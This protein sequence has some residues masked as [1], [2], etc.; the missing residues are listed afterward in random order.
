MN[1]LR[2]FAIAAAIV[3]VG[4]TANAADINVRVIN[5]SNGIWNT[6]FVIAAHPVGTSLFEVG[7]PASANLQAMAEGGDISG[8]VADLT[9]LG[10]T[11]SQDPAGGLLAPATS[12][13]V[14]L[15]TDG[16]SNVLLSAV[17]MLLPTNDGFA[18]LNGVVIPT[19]PGTYVFDVPA[20]DA[21]TE[22]NDE[23]I[24]GGGAPGAAGI[25][26]DPGGLNGTGG[27][28][29]AAADANSNVHIHRGNLGDTNGTG[30]VSDIDSTVHRWL[31]PVL[32]VVVTVQ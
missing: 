25:P 11:I 5:L 13:S 14:D 6:P 16:T 21:G 1:V 4:A 12:T 22:A 7:Q 2:K 26:A 19:T 29:A 3:S 24:T 31:N 27:T 10:A 32:R 30:G 20:Y 23:L 28:G 9:A 17:A 18:G 8:L 15:N